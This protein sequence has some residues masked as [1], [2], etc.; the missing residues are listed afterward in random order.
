VS[1]G[2]DLVVACGG[3][4]T[5]AACAEGVTGTRVPLAVIPLGTGNL[6]ARNISAQRNIPGFGQG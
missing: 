4:G 3:D 2:V 5:V 1:A 6:L